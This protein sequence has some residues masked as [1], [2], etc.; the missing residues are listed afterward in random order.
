[1]ND[2]LMSGLQFLLGLLVL[3]WCAWVTNSIYTHRGELK[4]LR[5]QNEMLERM[6]KIISRVI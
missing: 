2:Q 1:M 6:E 3:P 5:Q 4:L